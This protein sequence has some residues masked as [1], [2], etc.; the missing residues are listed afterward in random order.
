MIDRYW[1][2]FEQD[3]E[4]ENACCQSESGFSS[5]S[6]FRCFEFHLNEPSRLGISLEGRTDRCIQQRDDLR[7]VVRNGIHI[8]NRMV[9]RVVH[10]LLRFRARHES[11][12]AI[13]LVI[14]ILTIHETDLVPIDGNHVRGDA[15]S[16]IRR[17]RSN[18]IGSETELLRRHG[19]PPKTTA[20]NGATENGVTKLHFEHG[21]VRY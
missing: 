17:Q 16:T 13:R 3:R 11:P 4:S 12:A 1:P 19:K 10:V 2:R 14:R 20:G 15:S 8:V 6:I 9:S 18:L 7:I 5:C 21:D